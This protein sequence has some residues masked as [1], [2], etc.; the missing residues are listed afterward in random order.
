[1]QARLPVPYHRSTFEGSKLDWSDRERFTQL[2]DLHRDLIRLRQSDRRFRE[3][4]PGGV[5]GAVLGRRAFCLRYFADQA[6]EERL[7]VVNFGQQEKFSPAPEP[8]LAPP[9]G[10]EWQTL[11]TSEAPRYGGIGMAPITNDTGWTIFAE[12]TVALH[13]VPATRPR[14]QP[15]QRV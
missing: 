6:T 11:W 12:A 9:D 2:Y 1:M 3:L 4:K 13:A 15:K 14:R 8:L 5:D 7:L 10:Y